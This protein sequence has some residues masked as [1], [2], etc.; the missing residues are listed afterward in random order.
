[1][2]LIPEVPFQLDKLCQHVSSVLARKGHCV[3]CMAEGAGQVGG[4]SNG[5]A[6]SLLCAL[7]V[8]MPC[9]ANVQGRMR[10]RAGVACMPWKSSQEALDRHAPTC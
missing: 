8:C 1:V 2:C 9:K 10:C 6:R 3:V 4:C 7:V 5:V